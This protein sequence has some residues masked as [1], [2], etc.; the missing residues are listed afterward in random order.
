MMDD[1][2]VDE[3]EGCG[4]EA[5]S[6]LSAITDCSALCLLT[7]KDAFSWSQYG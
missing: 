4:S 3:L 5:V 7:K 2:W 6:K 1:G